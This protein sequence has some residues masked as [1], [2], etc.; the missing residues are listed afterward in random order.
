M[1]MSSTAGLPEAT[2]RSTAGA[3]SFGSTILSPWT[4][5]L[6]AIAAIRYLP[7]PE[8]SLLLVLLMD[9][10]WIS[11][12]W[13]IFNCLPIY[14]LDGGQMLSAVVG[15]NRSNLI[16]ITGM[17]CAGALGLLLF[18]KIG[19]WIMPA[20]MAYFV[21]INYQGLQQSSIRPSN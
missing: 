4:P 5:M 20:F 2:A 11:I 9:L 19:T 14:P 18:W 10:V 13:S 21:W 1:T 15:K 17:V 3:I 16:H 8:H 6:L 12:V 7:I